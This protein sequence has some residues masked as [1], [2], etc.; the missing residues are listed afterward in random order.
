[1]SKQIGNKERM[2]GKTPVSPK[3]G[4]A[5]RDATAAKRPQ[6][7]D[8]TAT[9]TSKP[10][11]SSGRTVPPPPRASTSTTSRPTTTRPGMTA[12]QRVQLRQAAARKKSGFR[13]RPMDIG[14]LVAGLIVIIL[15]VWLG[16]SNFA[17]SKNPGLTTAPGGGSTSN[18]NPA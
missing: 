14:L 13:L 17:S 11:A 3:P 2:D 6:Q 15:I 7:P 9:S 16:I 18:G 5:P 8:K 1:M 4:A 12:Q 10:V